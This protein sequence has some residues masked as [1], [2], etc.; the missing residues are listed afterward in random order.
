M[1]RVPDFC[2]LVCVGTSYNFPNVEPPKNIIRLVKRDATATPSAQHTEKPDNGSISETIPGDAFPGDGG[3]KDTTDWNGYYVFDNTTQLRGCAPGEPH[4]GGRKVVD[5]LR[6]AADGFAH[7]LLETP[8]VDLAKTL[9][10]A[11]AKRDENANRNVRRAAERNRKKLF[12]AIKRQ[13]KL[14]EKSMKH[15]RRQRMQTRGSRNARHRSPTPPP[16]PLEAATAS[17]DEVK[18]KLDEIEAALSSK[19][20]LTPMSDSKSK[21]KAKSKRTKSA[22]KLS[23]KRF[24]FSKRANAS[25]DDM[26]DSASYHHF[27]ELFRNLF[28]NPNNTQDVPLTN[29]SQLKDR[30][31]QIHSKKDCTFDLKHKEPANRKPH[32]DPSVLEEKND[33]VD[34][35]RSSIFSWLLNSS[36]TESPNQRQS[37]ATSTNSKQTKYNAARSTTSIDSS[38]SRDSQSKTAKSNSSVSQRPATT[39]TLSNAKE[40]D[41]SSE[42]SKRKASM[43]LE[44]CSS[45]ADAKVTTVKSQPKS[46]SSQTPSKAISS[47]VVAECEKKAKSKSKKSKK[48][49][50]RMR[51]R[52]TSQ[53][54]SPESVRTN[55]KSAAGTCSKSA[56]GTSSKSGV[57]T[58]SKSTGGPGLVEC[59]TLT[60]VCIDSKSS[61][62]TK[63]NTYAASTNSSPSR[64]SSVNK[65]LQVP[66]H[67]S[68]VSASSQSSVVTLAEVSDSS[69]SSTSPRTEV[70]VTSHNSTTAA[71]AVS[72]SNQRSPAA[73]TKSQEIA[74][75]PQN[76]DS[77][78][79]AARSNAKFPARTT[80]KC[81]LQIDAKSSRNSMSKS[82][83][84]RGS[85]N[86]VTSSPEPE[87]KQTSQCSSSSRKSKKPPRRQNRKP[88]GMTPS[89]ATHNSNVYER[90]KKLD[91]QSRKKGTSPND[92]WQVVSRKSN[93][94]VSKSQKSVSSAAFS[95]T[96]PIPKAPPGLSKR[97]I[98]LS[99]GGHRKDFNAVEGSAILLETDATYA[100]NQGESHPEDGLTF[101]LQTPKLL[102]AVAATA[103]TAATRTLSARDAPLSDTSK[104]VSCGDAQG[105]ETETTCVS[106]TRLR[107]LRS[108]EDSVLVSRTSA[109]DRKHDGASALPMDDMKAFVLLN[110]DKKLSDVEIA[111][112]AAQIRQI[113]GSSGAFFFFPWIF[114]TSLKAI[115]I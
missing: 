87:P 76:D 48:R 41:T 36:E 6:A 81:D 27:Q 16:P 62:A 106:E 98:P 90:M 38:T 30:T 12:S 31:S 2:S 45:T 57:G 55:S 37:T 18:A 5:V 14:T 44:S 63:S 97:P 100:D 7:T 83:R 105:C 72:A 78:K 56:A 54:T 96:H 43:P 11:N 70:S 69:E 99:S 58:S 26:S 80:P 95:H 8:R 50:N 77:S 46:A 1:S 29:E 94:N 23:G 75:T 103:A 21:E 10:K 91:E 85:H 51:S 107:T 25:E 53:T 60:S 71:A 115:Q 92:E 109:G 28:L 42:T 82:A 86:R 61:V 35:Q 114:E 22:A 59:E 39:V 111:E 112:R 33:G 49:R 66:V 17:D 15:R 101:E 68:A 34:K 47:T 104:T 32:T 20:T 84:R 24:N 88:H 113:L 102:A 79:N 3:D 19:S 40:T 73:R 89:H 74:M 64:D 110:S 52:G 4:Q 65:R 93:D 67:D 13:Q 108:A 9:I